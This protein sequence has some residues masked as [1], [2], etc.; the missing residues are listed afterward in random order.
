MSSVTTT[1]DRRPGSDGGRVVSKLAPD[2][3]AAVRRILDRAARRILAERQMGA[4]RV[5]KIGATREHPQH[6][7]QGDA[8]G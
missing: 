6:R 1:H 3:E 4:S 7:A 5:R 2:T 8:I